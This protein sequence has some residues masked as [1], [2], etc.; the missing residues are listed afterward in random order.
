MSGIGPSLFALAIV[1]GA[2][3]ALAEDERLSLVAKVVTGLAQDSTLL[4]GDLGKGIV[5]ELEPGAYE[6]GFDTGVAA[7]IYAEPTPCVFTQHARLDDQ[8]TT[9]TRFDF[10]AITGVSIVEQ[11][12]WEG[13]NAAI[14]ELQGPEA[15][16][17]IRDGEAWLP[18]PPFA[19]VVSSLTSDDLRAAA[20]ALREA[21][22]AP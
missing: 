13:L 14:I 9:D 21:C 5:N 17:Q 16:V 1:A 15:A 20:T 8:P 11:D 2:G 7:I 4:I 18:G 12:G 3:P 10:T 6:I 19:Y 22:P